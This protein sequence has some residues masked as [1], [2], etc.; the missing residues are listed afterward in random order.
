M[1]DR[2]ALLRQTT[3]RDPWYLVLFQPEATRAP[4]EPIVY[5][6]TKPP[7]GV[8]QPHGFDPDI[9]P[10]LDLLWFVMHTPRRL[11]DVFDVPARLLR[12]EPFV[13]YSHNVALVPTTH[14]GDHPWR[15]RLR[16][17]PPLLVL[18]PEQCLEIA[19]ELVA[20][21]GHAIRLVSPRNATQYALDRAWSEL[22][23]R[24]DIP[25]MRRPR[26]P[27]LRKPSV[28]GARYLSTI[29][30]ARQMEGHDRSLHF[31]LDPVERLRR[32]V[33]LHSFVAALG[34]AE[35]AKLPEEEWLGR[36]RE[37]LYEAWSNL[38]LSSVLVSPG[39]APRYRRRTTGFFRR[40]A[41]S[42]DLEIEGSVLCTLAAH[43]AA[44]SSSLLAVTSPVPNAV[45][46]LYVQL[47]RHCQRARFSR[48]A[49]WKLLRTLGR[50][51][52]ESLGPA[53]QA[54]GYSARAMT[55]FSDF[56]IGLA[57]LPGDSSPLAC[58]LPINYLPLTPLTRRLQFELEGQP[59]FDWTSGVRVMVAECL[60]PSDPIFRISQGLWN[61]ISRSVNSY[62]G[63]SCVVVNVPTEA[64]LQESLDSIQPDV[65]VLS[66]HGSYSVSSNAAT[67]IVGGQPTFL[68]R[69]RNVPPLVI[70]SACHVS[71]RA[72]GAVTVADLLIRSGAT[73]VIGTLVPIHVARNGFLMNRL[74]IYLCE[75][76]AGRESF[77]TLDLL[78]RHVLS[79][80]AVHDVYSA[81]RRVQKWAFSRHRGLTVDEEFKNTRSRG[82][83]RPSHIHRDTETVL[84]EM[85]RERGFGEI[86]AST[87]ASV[88]YF[89][90]SLFYTVV[91][92]ADRFVISRAEED[93]LGGPESPSS[94]RAMRRS[95]NVA[96]EVP[97]ADRT[98]RA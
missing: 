78:W 44:A 65:L 74:F 80:H 51:L 82:R 92:R 37:L 52:A 90:E 13:D 59:R 33:R 29:F 96:V 5:A 89:P 63:C 6:G 40:A 1:P 69:L 67:L 30:L 79:T 60:D 64:R 48:P 26:A 12:L 7:D 81:S 9:V 16:A 38:R 91:G 15:E 77:S 98:T 55:A 31:G 34:N 84:L 68:L 83:L 8:T 73:A 47:E 72:T 53:F 88:G 17:E 61:T 32:H 41:T 43:R 94:S 50:L 25:V 21:S 56:P 87:L 93:D 28:E 10:A 24:Y 22:A 57:L 46:G 95:V 14:S 4:Y 39:T 18:A 97:D 19:R 70:L 54:I 45:F 23:T 27:R 86:L 85:A 3:M 11:Q 42:R 71:P 35:A 2:S 58:R 76:I 75:T 20:A 62:S 36:R 66:A 49:A